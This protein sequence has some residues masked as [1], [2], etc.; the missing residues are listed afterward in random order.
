MLG[1]TFTTAEPPKA[2]SYRGSNV[3]HREVDREAVGWVGVLL[4]SLAE[5]NRGQDHDYRRSDDLA[6][7]VFDVRRREFIALLGGAAAWPIA[8]R[9]RDPKKIARIGVL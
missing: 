8:A 5:C 4:R 2:D 3:R 6:H 7:E 9:A 1:Q